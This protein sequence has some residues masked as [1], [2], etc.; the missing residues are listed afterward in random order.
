MSLPW[1]RL[2]TSIAQ[3]YKVLD[4]VGNRNHRAVAVY[5]FGLAY[6]G[7]QG[8][9]GYIPRAA[10]PFLHATPKDAEA[11]CQVGLWHAEHGGWQ[12]ND[13]AEYQPSDDTTARRSARA[14]WLNCQRWHPKGCT[15]APKP[16]DGPPERSFG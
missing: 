9:G 13:W 5:V 10:L 15:C 4:L 6:A 7:Q 2:D 11:L 14:K 8:T 12:V 3:N 1:I 16:P